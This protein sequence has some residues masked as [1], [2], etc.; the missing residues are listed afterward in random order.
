MKE[1][2]SNAIERLPE[3]FQVELNKQ[4]N[5]KDKNVQEK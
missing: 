4:K 5:Y 2:I 1:I 3:I